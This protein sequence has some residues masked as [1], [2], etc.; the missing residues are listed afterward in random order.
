M[1]N[2]RELAEQIFDIKNIK[3]AKCGGSHEICLNCQKCRAN[4][5]DQVCNDFENLAQYIDHTLL[6]PEGT[7]NQ[8][9]KLCKE[10]D[11]NMFKSVCVNPCFI[12]LSDYQLTKSIVCTVIGFPLGAN[13]TNVKVFETKSAIKSGAKE[14]DLVINNGWMKSKKYNVI[15]DELSQVAKV[16]SDNNVL[17]KLIIETCLL[18]DTEIIIASLLAKKAG[19]DFVKTSTGFNSAGAKKE[20]IELMRSVVGPKMGVKASGGIRDREAALIML[21]AGANRIGASKGIEIIGK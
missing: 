18:N 17:S 13:E 9:K 19:F 10:A 6:K 20:N 8:V 12:E 16:A 5:E 7:S 15:L 11:E 4:D 21:K 14:I 1:K 2:V 3:D